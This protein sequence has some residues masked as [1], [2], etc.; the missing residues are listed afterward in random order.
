[1]LIVI[2]VL[3]TVPPFLVSLPNTA[4]VIG[5][6]FGVVRLSGFATIVLQAF[7][8]T[9]T[10]LAVALIQVPFTQSP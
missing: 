10:G 6:A 4:I 5:V 1:M 9:V 7:T 2:A 3:L 8:V